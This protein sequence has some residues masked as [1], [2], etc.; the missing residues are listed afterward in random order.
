MRA[1]YSERIKS[2]DICFDCND[3]LEFCSKSHTTIFHHLNIQ[4]NHLINLRCLHL[5]AISCS[6]PF[7]ILQQLKVLKKKCKN[8]FLQLRKIIRQTQ[9][10]FKAMIYRQLIYAFK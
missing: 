7:E 6:K 3:I 5:S 8:A 1:K 9:Y 4:Q 2:C 10:T